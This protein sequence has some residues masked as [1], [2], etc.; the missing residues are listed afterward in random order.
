MFFSPNCGHCKRLKPVWEQL[1]VADLP[2]TIAVAEVDCTSSMDLCQRCAA[3]ACTG[4]MRSSGR[5]A[6]AQAW[7][8][9]SR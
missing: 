1:A 3:R 9:S 6:L 5:P 7:E 8:W 2:L 4:L